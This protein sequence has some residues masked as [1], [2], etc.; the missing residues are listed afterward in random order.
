MFYLEGGGVLHNFLTLSHLYSTSVTR[1][2]WW[3]KTASPM[4]FLT[5]IHKSV[6]GV[7]EPP[8][9]L[10]GPPIPRGCPP[11][12]SS[13]KD[14]RPSWAWSRT[15]GNSFC[16]PCHH[17]GTLCPCCLLY[18]NLWWLFLLPLLALALPQTMESCQEVYWIRFCSWLAFVL[19]FSS[20]KILLLDN[21]QIYAAESDF[22]PQP[23]RS[24]SNCL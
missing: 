18:S 22:F 7:E 13:L 17:S 16:P 23:E 11:H 6:T 19:S 4:K 9:A 5:T 10:E 2:S 14:S 8:F 12:P 20:L 15:P 1:V 24:V 3:D 21:F